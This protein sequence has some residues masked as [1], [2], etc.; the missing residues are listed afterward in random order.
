MR[1]RI[2]SLARLGQIGRLPRRDRERLLVRQLAAVAALAAIGALATPSLAS[3]SA[4]GRYCGSNL[5]TTT[6]GGY[7]V[8][9]T[10]F[11]AG[12]TMN[13][14]SVRYV[15]NQWLRRSLARQSGYPALGRPFF[16]G[17][18]T[19]HC[20]KIGGYHRWQC[21]EFTSNTWFRFSGSVY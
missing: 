16:D 19:W 7:V 11:R 15:A 20:H 6:R 5:S 17:Y 9:L 18:V 14:A 2:S 4:H 12:G 3:A 8:T 1:K 13:C 10:G 21:A